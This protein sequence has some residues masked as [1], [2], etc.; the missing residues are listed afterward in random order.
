MSER[1]KVSSVGDGGPQTNYGSIDNDE[2]DG[3]G[4]APTS[5]GGG[6][7]VG[8]GGGGGEG[9]G[10]SLVSAGAATGDPD[11]AAPLSFGMANGN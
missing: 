11:T 5:P 3:K 1:F 2:F 10:D 8:G 4:S 9:D 6:D 7:S